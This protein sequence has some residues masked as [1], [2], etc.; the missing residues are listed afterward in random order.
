MTSE[1]LTDLV[2]DLVRY[3]EALKDILL[4]SPDEARTIAARALGSEPTA[5]AAVSQLDPA[6]QAATFVADALCQRDWECRDDGSER[7][8]SYIERGIGENCQ[9]FLSQPLPYLDACKVEALLDGTHWRDPLLDIL[10]LASGWCRPLS[11]AEKLQAIE[12]I[13]SRMLDPKREAQLG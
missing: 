2:A 4:L 1:Q 13:G 9:R 8:L 6:E 3:R 12:R 5:E 10:D 7:G 11:D